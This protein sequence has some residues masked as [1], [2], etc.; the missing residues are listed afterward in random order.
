MADPRAPAGREKPSL[1]ARLHRRAGETLIRARHAF[2]PRL[3]LGVRLV[4]LDDRGRVFLVRH[5]YLPGLH[6]PGGGVDPGETCRDAAIREAA[7]EGALVLPEPP[8]LFQVYRNPA[9]GRHDHVV[10]YVARGVRVE[11]IRPRGLEIVA[12]GFHP[13]EPLPADATRPT[14]DRLAE[15]IVGEPVAECW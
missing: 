1:L 5:S 10:L 7:E 11:G 4:A 3:S 6:L 8:T 12:A 2:T 9:G 13:T 15:V 14:R